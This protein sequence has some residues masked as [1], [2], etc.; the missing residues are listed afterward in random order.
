M[1]VHTI[2]GLIDRELLEVKDIIDEG[3]NYRSIATEWYL[4]GKLVRRDAAV[5]ILRGHAL[6]GEQAEL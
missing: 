5:S 4:D 6:S 1:L 2:D 3:D